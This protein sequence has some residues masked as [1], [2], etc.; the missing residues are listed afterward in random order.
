[1][2]H[3]EPSFS[4]YADEEGLI[5][6]GIQKQQ[7]SKV[8]QQA[9]SEFSF[10][11]TIGSFEN[12]KIMDNKNQTF[13]ESG[14]ILEHYKKMIKEDPSNPV[15]LK[16]YAHLLQSNGDVNGA[17]EYYFRA[18]Q[19]DPKDGEILMKYAKL[20]W[21][22]HHDQ[23]R[24]LGYFEAA[25][26]AAPNDSDV[27]A[28]Y[29]SLMW[30]I[31]EDEESNEAATPIQESLAVD[32]NCCDPLLLRNY[33]RFLQQTKGDLEGAEKYYLRAVQADPRDGL[34]VS[35]YAQLMW[36]LHHDQEKAT[37]FFEQSVQV[38]PANSDVLAAYAKFLWEADED[39]YEI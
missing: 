17:E 5:E 12:L 21:E 4:V 6:I 1:M 32:E 10:G 22:L 36:E 19:A 7:N 23:D 13:D 2:L 34:V 14:D 33:A 16:K 25:V 28:A 18:T 20:V 37:S 29:A 8:K 27:L 35:Q 39:A 15:F 26:S 30:E 24:A 38:A 9:S 3:S 31:D 11:K